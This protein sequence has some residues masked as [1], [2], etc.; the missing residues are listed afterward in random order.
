MS[1]RGKI[2][3]LILLLAVLAFRYR[4]YAYAIL[5]HC[6]HGNYASFPGHRIRLP[7]FWWEER[8]TSQ[9]ETYL[10]RRAN[11]HSELAQLSQIQVSHI[12]PA[13]QMTIT[14][15][16][17]EAMDQI[18]KVI[19]SLNAKNESASRETLVTIKAN[20]MTLYCVRSELG[21]PL[22]PMAMLNCDAPKFPYSI[23]MGPITQ[24]NEA[25][26]VLSTLE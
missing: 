7:L 13:F 19:S 4:Q 25:K 8:D 3:I 23:S 17:Q 24:E 2:S 15:T 1:S 11:T 9:W 5:W 14:N 20:K 10:L 6:E 21:L 12:I 22:F 18:Q 26:S 16:D